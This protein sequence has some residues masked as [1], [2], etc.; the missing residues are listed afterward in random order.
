[1]PAQTAVIWAT[2]LL[3]D[4]KSQQSADRELSQLEMSLLFDI[5]C[6]AV[7]ALSD[8]WGE[9]EISPS[10]EITKNKMPFGLDPIQDVCK[11]TFTAKKSDAQL[12]VEASFLILSEKLSIAA[13]QKQTETASQQNFSK[14]LLEHIQ[15]IPVPLT[16]CFASVNVNIQDLISLSPEDTILLDKTI[17]QPVDVL[18]ND[19]IVFRARPAKFEDSYAVVI[20]EL[21]NK[22]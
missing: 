7:K 6:C 8:V 4:T 14:V 19:K 20:T 5:S 12:P 16:I 3:G 1:M 13:G 10:G 2:Q 21:Y 17:G 11:I 9:S 15:S 18:Y 22:K